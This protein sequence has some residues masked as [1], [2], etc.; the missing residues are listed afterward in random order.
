MWID[1]ISYVCAF[2]FTVGVENND[3]YL[4]I[5]FSMKL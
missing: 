3:F 5:T 1:V 4:Y 2:A